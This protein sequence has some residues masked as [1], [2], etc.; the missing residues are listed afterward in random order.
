MG[1]NKSEVPI[2]IS[3]VALKLHQDGKSL[4]EIGEIYTAAIV[5]PRVQYIIKKYGTMKKDPEIN[6]KTNVPTGLCPF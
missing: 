6:A 1:R 5:Q 2:D 4:R 3:E